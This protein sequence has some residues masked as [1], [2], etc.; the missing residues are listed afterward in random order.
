[1]WPETNISDIIL[2][3]QRA[4]AN[5]VPNITSIITFP[6]PAEHSEAFL[7]SSYRTAVEIV[8]VSGG[9]ICKFIPNHCKSGT[10]ASH[11][12]KAYCYAKQVSGLFWG[13]L[14]ALVLL[15]GDCGA[16]D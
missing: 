10:R 13:A 6:F 14:F 1:M 9:Q 4:H 12:Q 7:L 15:Q 5:I 11:M 3:Y 8:L 16:L 2:F